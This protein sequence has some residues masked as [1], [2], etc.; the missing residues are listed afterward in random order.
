MI[1]WNEQG[2]ENSDALDSVPAQRARAILGI[3]RP[4]HADTSSGK[5]VLRDKISIHSYL[6]RNISSHSW[7]V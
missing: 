6:V 7:V 5:S 3:T 2:L 4:K 1:S